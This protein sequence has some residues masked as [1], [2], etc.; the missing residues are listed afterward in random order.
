M[1]IELTD[2]EFVDALRSAASIL[3]QSNEGDPAFTEAGENLIELRGQ[4]LVK[5]FTA[6][7]TYAKEHAHCVHNYFDFVAPE[8]R[9]TTHSS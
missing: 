8:K 9:S 1:P 7:H 6:L 4:N 3:S 5:F 2:T